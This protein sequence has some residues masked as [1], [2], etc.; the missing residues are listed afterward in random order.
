[1]IEASYR[2]RTSA[3]CM[4]LTQAISRLHASERWA[5]TPQLKPVSDAITEAIIHIEA[6][7]LNICQPTEQP[8]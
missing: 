7:K 8:T 2:F 3:I 4:C 6:I 5:D 1:M